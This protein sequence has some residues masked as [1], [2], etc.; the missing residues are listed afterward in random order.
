MAN[1]NQS[2]IGRA[3]RRR[4]DRRLLRGDGRYLADLRLPGAL[5]VAFLRSPHAHAL[6]KRIDAGRARRLPG[7]VAVFDGSDVAERVE[8]L[9]P[10]L[11]KT[12]PAA[13]QERARPRIRPE[14]QPLLALGKV[15]YVGEPVAL[16]V[17]TDR[18]VAE[19]ALELIDVDY[20]PLPPVQGVDDALRTDAPLLH[21]EW[22][23]N[24]TVSLQVDKGQVEQAFAQAEV[25]VRERLRSHRYAA[26]PIETRGVAATVDPHDG[27]LSVW[28]STQVPHAV[29]DVLAALFQL[30]L[31]DIRVVA[32]DVGGG[33]GV[34]GHVYVEDVLIPLLARDLGRP[35]RWVEDRRE[36]LQAAYHAREQIHEIELAADADGRL[37]GLRDRILFD[38]GAHN[39]LGMVL[40]Y[41]TV[42]HLFGPYVVPAAHVEAIAAVTNK[43][44]H[45][46]YRGAGRPE[47]VFAMER[48]LERL[49][50]ALSLDPAEVRLR[51]L[52][53]PE[54]MPYDTGLLYRDGQPLV[55]DSGDYP[56]MYR[57]ALELVEYDRWR[58]ESTRRR[59][60][61]GGC[62]IGIGLA[63][64]V[65][66]TGI[67]PFESGSVAVDPSGRVR[68]AT[69][70]CSQG[71]GHATTFAQLVAEVLG[72][73]LE[74]IDVVGG[75]T[76]AILHGFGTI[77]SRSMTTGGSA[78]AAAATAVH[79]KALRVGAEL[80]EASADDLELLDGAVQVKGAPDRVISLGEIA[81]RLQPGPGRPGAETAG[82]E[83][84]AYF[85][86]STVT[87]ASG[88]HAVVLEIDTET[89]Q[90][91]LLRYAVVHD[92]GK[93][94]NP[95]IADGQITGGVAQGIGGALLEEVV[96]DQQGQVLTSSLMDYLLPTATDL[97]EPLLDHQEHLSTRNPLGI[98][99]LGEGGA[100]A[101]PAAIAN[102][103]E[104]AL[105]SLAVVVRETPLSPNRV[106]QLIRESARVPTA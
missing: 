54:S 41:N 33:F 25:V 74:E 28:A 65:E 2:W 31:H 71:Q 3:V 97:P 11:W 105:R 53:P 20:E 57:R 8:P 5:E 100:I 35:V 60:R 84:E 24:V 10:T 96:Y 18:Y 72:V 80:L 91:G 67:G 106:R 27:R 88:V 48:M 87:Y 103:V 13:I 42:A 59:G 81:R 78:V 76:G 9:T 99:G 82:L 30:P 66:G 22:G 47:A 86:P 12:P 83:E 52:V 34:K 64:Y 43:T 69:G 56:T 39:P 55:Y 89:G 1:G 23:D 70:S 104:D 44:P 94:V 45:A 7:V 46:P 90:V 51:N 95:T 102:A 37:L 61:D 49:A 62:L 50:T 58:A 93:V 98:K 92:C 38:S 68:V 4:E 26:V 29:R 77:A 85:E 14:R 21:D 16:V 63:G 40:P 73:R 101:P 6:V 79:H 32:P 19:D 75:D 17:A 15:R 36:H